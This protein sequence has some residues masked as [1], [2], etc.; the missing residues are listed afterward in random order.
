MDFL[1]PGAAGSTLILVLILAW[2]LPWKGYALWLAAREGHRWWFIILL[3]TNTLA[4][5]DII[6]IFLVGRPSQKKQPSEEEDTSA[7]IEST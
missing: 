7:D 4:I 1:L 6:Y 2:T 3:V 5:L